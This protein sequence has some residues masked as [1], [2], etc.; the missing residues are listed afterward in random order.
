MKAMNP[1]QQPPSSPSNGTSLDYLNQIAPSTPRKGVGGMINGPLR[2]IHYIIG[3]LLLLVVIVIV[4]SIV[5]GTINGSTKGKIERLSVRLDA[6]STI[7]ND[8]TTKIKGSQLRVINSNL[9]LLLSD[10]TREL[11]DPL[12]IAGVTTKNI[13]STIKKEE[14]ADAITARLED[15]RLNGVYDSTYAREM[16]YQVSATLALMKEIYT[17]TSSQ[18]MKTVLEKS[19]ANLEPTVE[20]LT[21]FTA[22]TE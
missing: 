19:Y 21:D 20:Q 5:M 9:K 17:A 12:K 16:A 22:Q 6:T 14:S 10:T 8:S 3:G 7:V 11:A 15:A 4:L 13:S 1:Q 18:S 2:P